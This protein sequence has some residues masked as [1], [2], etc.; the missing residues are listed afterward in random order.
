MKALFPLILL[1]HCL[2]FVITL[3]A[4]EGNH[5]S[6]QIWNQWRLVDGEILLGNFLYSKED[7][8][9]LQLRDG[10]IH[11]L[12]VQQLIV[13][14][15]LLATTKIKKYQAQIQ[16]AFLP[17]QS[18]SNTR[19][20]QQFSVAWILV[21]GIIFC[22]TCIVFRSHLSSIRMVIAVGLVVVVLVFSSFF[23]QYTRS[24][25]SDP[26]FLRNAF[27]PYK[28]WVQ[29]DYDEQYFYVS[30]NGIP[31]HPMMVGIRSWQSQV[32]LPQPYSGNNRWSI[33]LHPQWSDTPISTRNNFFRGAIAL[34]VNGVPIFNALNNRGE[35]ALLA[36]ELDNWGGHCGRADDY[37]YHIVPAHLSKKAELPLAFALDGFA[38]YGKTEPD[39]V[40]MQALDNCNGHLYRDNSYH[41]HAISTYPYA[42]GAFRGKV[43]IDPR[44]P[45]PENQIFP[46]A[47]AKPIR[48]PGKLLRGATIQQYEA[49]GI[50]EYAVTYQLGNQIGKVQYRWNQQAVYF[51][52]Y[53]PGGKSDSAMYPLKK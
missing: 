2:F 39:G 30:S 49:T 12:P 16:Q 26:T 23:S 43:Q 47:F 1:F 53:P 22:I 9:V 7:S 44:T 46:Q 41:Y 36:G 32:P 27:A 10:R 38:I 3:K 8:L 18:I 5:F 42:V 25:A 19:T 14:D 35:D 50:N 34:A 40:A 28:E 29:T 31:Q 48:P 6:G 4:H 37:H 33:P 21:A 20:S 24:A 15:Q 51:Y 17:G 13:Q 45:A 11:V 52:F